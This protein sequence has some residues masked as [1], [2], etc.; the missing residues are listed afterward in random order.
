MLSDRRN[1]SQLVLTI[2]HVLDF[3]V[4]ILSEMAGKIS[5]LVDIN[6][7]NIYNWLEW[8]SGFGENIKDIAG[9]EALCLELCLDLV[10][11]AGRRRVYF[12]DGGQKGTR[13][14]EEDEQGSQSQDVSEVLCE[15]AKHCV[16]VV[17]DGGAFVLERV[18][19]CGLCNSRCDGV[20]G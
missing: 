16:V 18:E 11:G 6:I 8:A 7:H 9:V 13:Q 19:I 17:G 15:I 5:C 2:S 14:L 12:V 10:F 3:F 4:G 20:M 1:G